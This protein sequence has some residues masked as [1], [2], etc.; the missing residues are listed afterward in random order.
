M[1]SLGLVLFHL[2]IVSDS[3]SL[4]TLDQTHIGQ[5]CIVRDVASPTAAP[6][7]A[8]W[9]DEIGFVAGE[10]VTLMARGAIGGDPL[11]VRVGTSTFALRRAEAACVQV[12]AA[13]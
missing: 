2:R 12:E 9:L 3:S 6:E 11:V 5:R 13:P 1:R 4:L 10:Q 7:W 8:R